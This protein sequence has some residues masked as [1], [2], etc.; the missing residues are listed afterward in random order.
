MGVELCRKGFSTLKLWTDWDDP[1]RTENITVLAN[2]ISCVL[3]EALLDRVGTFS[4]TDS[5]VDGP[6][7][8]Q[9][10]VPVNRWER[11]CVHFWDTLFSAPVELSDQD[12]RRLFYLLDDVMKAASRCRAGHVC[13]N[14]NASLWHHIHEALARE[15]MHIL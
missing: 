12:A 4:F 10:A 9:H 13:A 6:L 1:S 7:R 11:A 3:D 5:K 15:T 8:H 14:M 2:V